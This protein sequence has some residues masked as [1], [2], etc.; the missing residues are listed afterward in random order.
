[1]SDS[2]RNGGSWWAR[3]SALPND[4]PAKTVV[5]TLAVALAG[6]VLVAYGRTRILCTACVEDGVPP[7]LV[8]S[9]MGWVTGEY[10]MLPGSTSTRKARADRTGKADSRALE[11]S[12]FIGR[13]MRAPR[14]PLPW[15]SSDTS[16]GQGP[17]V[18]S[19]ETASQVFQ[20]RS[21]ASGGITRRSMAW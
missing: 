3:F 4:N 12:R 2:G 7:W 17:V 5:I 10:G 9:G 8:N 15:L 19:G 6:S 18:P 11:I 13:C 21:R 16:A 14:S 20:R 1:M